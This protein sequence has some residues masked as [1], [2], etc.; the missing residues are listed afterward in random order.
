MA[1]TP[2]EPTTTSTDPKEIERDLLKIL[3]KSKDGDLKNSFT[4]AKEDKRVHEVVVGV[5][6]SLSTDFF[7]KL[8]PI[9]KTYF[10]LTTEAVN[11][12]KAGISPEFQVY[13]AVKVGESIDMKSL[14]GRLDPKVFNIGFGQAK[15]LKML[16]MNKGNISRTSGDG[17]ERE[18]ETLNELIVLRDTEG[19][20]KPGMTLDKKQIKKLKARKLATE[21]KL[22]SYYVEKG[23][24]Y[25]VKRIRITPM[26]VEEHL[27]EVKTT[28][29]GKNKGKK[30]GK[31]NKR[32]G[33]KKD[34]AAT[35]ARVQKVWETIPK[36]KG[37]NTDVFGAPVSGGYLHPLMKV[38]SE[39]RKVL[40]QM[41]FEEMPTN[42]WVESAF[43]NFDALFQ[44]QFHPARDAHDTFFIKDPAKA[45]RLPGEYLRVVQDMHENGGGDVGNCKSI[46]YGYNWSRLEAEKTLLRTHT[47]AVSARML[48]KL[49]QA[50]KAGPNKGTFE[51][52][53]YFSIDRV[54][55]NES[56]DKTHLC[57]FH[58][59]EFF[60][61]DRGLSLGHLIGLLRTFFRLIGITKLRFKPAY[62]PY[63]EPSMEI[64]GYHPGLGK[65][66]EVGNSGIFRPE[67]LAPMGIPADV[68]VIAGGVS[69]ERP[70]M[71]KYKYDD[72][73]HMFSNRGD[74]KVN[75]GKVMAR[76][77]DCSGG[78]TL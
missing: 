61:A 1:T 23:P 25:A 58:Q 34:D 49:G 11:I 32:G 12:L 73:R 51:P 74:M 22:T 44:P 48:Y 7:V 14:R 4:Y 50:F 40:L 16:S 33:S 10:E 71:I 19:G 47:T 20:Q 39:F 42:Q 62:N 60:V 9:H 41:G 77:I 72:I 5:L 75:R 29:K 6:K 36:W 38:R 76:V 53:K 43:W 31:K 17:T 69:L 45:Q 35:P 52:K 56:M 30:G 78:A 28:N 66:T 54:F 46:G 8:K 13:Q 67:M 63:T 57:E 26:L 55:R 24:E 68:N 18:D 37:A 27:R 70:T 21:C 2:T 15:K 65:W 64:F 3:S 59:V